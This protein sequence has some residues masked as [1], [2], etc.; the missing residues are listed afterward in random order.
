ML[1]EASF[2]GIIASREVEVETASLADCGYLH[3]V[4][5]L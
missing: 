4:G 5:I 1:H 2:S 3:S